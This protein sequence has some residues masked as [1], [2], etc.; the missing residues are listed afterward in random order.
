[1]AMLGAPGMG[2]QQAFT[3]ELNPCCTEM[4]QNNNIVTQLYQTQ[5]QDASQQYMA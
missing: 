3:F 2:Q 1:M 5:F 4:P